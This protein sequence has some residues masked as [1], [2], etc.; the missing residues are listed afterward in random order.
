MNASKH[1]S[2]ANCLYCP[3]GYEF[4]STI[5]ACKVCGKGMFQDLAGTENASCG[6]CPI[7]QYNLGK[8]TYKSNIEQEAPAEWPTGDAKNWPVGER[9]G[10]CTCPNGKSYAVGDNLDG[11]ESLACVNGISELR[12]NN[13]DADGRYRKVICDVGA[14]VD[15]SGVQ[16]K[17]CPVGM[18]ASNSTSECT[19]CPAGRFQNLPTANAYQCQFCKKGRYFVSANTNCTDCPAGKF[20]FR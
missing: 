16:C 17:G 3:K 12:C 18:F 9:S 20:Q 2:L 15:D 13:K 11:C 14:A 8:I 4:V 19:A 7:G 6:W 10:I 1:E 5:S